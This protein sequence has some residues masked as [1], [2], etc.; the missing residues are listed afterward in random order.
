MRGRLWQ[1]GQE[2][3]ISVGA[4]FAVLE[5]AVVRGEKL[6]PP[7]DPRI[8]SSHFAND[9]ELL[10]IQ[11]DAKLRA[12]KVA[13]KAVDGLDSAASVNVKRSP[14]PLR[15]EGSAADERDAPH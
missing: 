14:V 9:F 8:V 12:P 13:S 10:E 2:I 4:A 7:L 1:T 11:E 3:G 15:I 5:G 6:E